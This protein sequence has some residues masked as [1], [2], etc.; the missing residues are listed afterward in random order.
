MDGRVRMRVD[1]GRVQK[2]GTLTKFLAAISLVDLPALF[3]GTRD[4]LTKPGIGYERLQMEATI[5]GKDVQVHKLAMRSSAMDVAGKGVMD[6]DSSFIDLLL[7]VR[8]FQNLDVLLSKVPIIRD[9]FGGAANSL[10]RKVYRM[11]GPIADAEVE[12]ISQEEA[13]M[14]TPGA[15]DHLLKMPEAWFGKGEPLES[16]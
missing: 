5:D 13:G 11:R 4:D 14:A 1:N 3:F 8:P 7:V 6:V 2:G 9:M 10:M 15:F 16:K 12:P